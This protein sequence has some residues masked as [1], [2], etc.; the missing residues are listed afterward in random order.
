[1]HVLQLGHDR[2]AIL[3]YQ[4][5]IF[6][7]GLQV[8]PLAISRKPAW[9]Q[10]HFFPIEVD[11]ARAS[12][13]ANVLWMYFLPR[14]QYEIAMLEPMDRGEDEAADAFAARVQAA[15]AAKLGLKPSRWGNREKNSFM[16]RDLDKFLEAGFNR[17]D[18]LP[19]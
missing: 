3:R 2:R 16:S 5:F 7:L 9:I 14:G 19:P 13:I 18:F 6:S 8:L 4:K 15:T 12:F 10:R 11:T 17:D 1:M